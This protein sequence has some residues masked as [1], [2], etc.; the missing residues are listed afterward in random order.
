MGVKGQKAWNK[1]NLDLEKI[2]GMY[3]NGDSVAVIA[4]NFCVSHNAIYER[5]KEMRITRTNSESHIGLQTREK[6]G[7]WKGGRCVCKRSGYVVISDGNGGLTREH[8]VVAEKMLGRPLEEGEV[9]HHKNGDRSDN[10]PE[11]LEVLSNQSIH[12]KLHIIH[13]EAVRRG[14]SPKRSKAA[15]LA[16][17]EVT[18]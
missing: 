17:M 3:L 6:N 13:E 15:L 11:N 12:M 4:K 14:K 8:R 5:L 18:E 10:S 9:V 16:V 2:K 7:N 1:L